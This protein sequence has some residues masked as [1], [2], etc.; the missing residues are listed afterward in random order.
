M[1]SSW[2]RARTYVLATLLAAL[3]APV[4]AGA[5]A[6]PASAS[7]PSF[8]SKL[9]SLTNADRARHGLA[10]LQSSSTLVSIARAWSNHMAATGQLAHNPS[11]ASQVSGWSS[12]GENAAV[13]ASAT[14]AESLFMARAGHRANI[15]N[16]SYNKVGIGVT[17]GKN[18]NYWFTIDFEQT[19]GYHAPATTAP[20]PVKH[21]TT[22]V[23]R[24]S[25]T[26][27]AA[28]AARAARASRSAARTAVP[29]AKVAV[30]P[31]ASPAAAALTARL[32]ALDARSATAGI[33]P[34]GAF[35]A[36][37][38]P[39]DGRVPAAVSMVVCGGL[40]VTLLAGLATVRPSRL[41]NPFRR[42]AGG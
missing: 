17:V 36:P 28:R 26:A 18:G 22:H 34:A 11:L 3:A 33:F 4:L 30:L 20:K 41:R 10:P 38:P 7:V 21:T 8:E 14:Q 40:A 6:A 1:I 25:S 23:T 12:L 15:L 35:D 39:S 16:R 2:R 31:V 19:S 13:A 9:L 24:T 32:A 5:L 42:A 27:A 37:T 29:A